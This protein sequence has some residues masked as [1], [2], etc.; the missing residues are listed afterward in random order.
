VYSIDLS[1]KKGLIFG[2]ANQRSVAWA[3]AEKL[4]QAGAQMAFSYQGEKFEDNVR[5]LTADF[6]E[7]LLVSCDV[8]KDDDLD[9]MFNAVGEKF[10]RLDFLVHSV[11]FAPLRTFDQPF[12]EVAREDWNVAM[13]ASAYSLIAMAKR[14]KPLMQGGG[15]ITAISFLAAERVVP[16]YKLMGIAKAALEAN[17]IYLAYEFGPQN[18][19]VNAISAGPLRTLSARAI[20]G[21]GDMAAKGGRYSMMKRNITQ[22]QVGGVALSLI[23]DELGSGVT[24]EVIYVDHGYHAMAMLFDE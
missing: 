20:P 8:T 10:G 13:D 15:S 18:V 9:Y 4:H 2:L 5:K 7:P 6:R 19:R 24:G 23:A 17:V 14:A 11:A 3:I 1:D 12:Y 21:F 16:K 22:E